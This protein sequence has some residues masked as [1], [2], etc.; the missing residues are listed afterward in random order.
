MLHKCKIGSTGL[1]LI[2]L[3]L[4][5]LSSCTGPLSQRDRS[6][7]AFRKDGRLVIHDPNGKE[8]IAID[9]EIAATRAEKTR[10]LMWRRHLSQNAG[11]LFVFDS[12]AEQQFWMR[13]TYL[14]LDIVFIDEKKRVLNIARSTQPL[15]DSRYTSEGPAQFVLEVNAGFCQKYRI[16]PGDR[17]AWQ[18]I[19][20]K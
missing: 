8:R 19:S 11:M 5:S 12:P 3:I 4:A 15:S 9:I 7:K 17:V 1:V 14:P 18:P 10:G 2:L 20:L 13:H 16:E 6:R